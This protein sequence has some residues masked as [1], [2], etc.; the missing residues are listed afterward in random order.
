MRRKGTSGFP[1]PAA[2]P[3]GRLLD[4]APS[5]PSVMK[6]GV[7]LTMVWALYATLLLAVSGRE[8]AEP[9]LPALQPTSDL[10]TLLAAGHA[11][12][13]K[14]PK[15]HLLRNSFR[16]LNMMG[17][18]EGS[19]HGGEW[20][21]CRA[22]KEAELG[23]DKKQEQPGFDK[24]LH[25]VAPRPKAGWELEMSESQDAEWLG[26]HSFD[27]M[28][29]YGSEEADRRVEK[30]GYC[31]VHMPSIPRTGSTWFRAL[32][33]TATS[34]PSFSMWPEGGTLKERYTAFSS[35]DPCGASLDHM[36]GNLRSKA[37]FPCRDLRPPNATSP[38]LYKS[39]TPFFPSY[40]KPSLM[41][42]DTCM[43]VLLVRNP[44]DNHD[45]WQ[46]YMAG[47]APCLRDYLPV[48]QGHLSHWVAAAGDIPIYVFRY[49]D[50]LLRAEEVLRRILNTLPGGWNWSEESI[51]RAMSLF[52][53]KKP[54]KQ[55]CGAGVPRASLAEVEMVRRHYG[56]YMRH[57]GYR[58][59]ET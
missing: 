8:R 24:Y 3:A 32:F 55:K 11:A 52:G 23:P 57:F 17:F 41:P 34:Q 36:E 19:G 16:Q 47:K 49:E 43:L 42:E 26:L 15:P 54:F 53:P 25:P 5:A 21:T 58:F 7:A 31:R 39:H 35:D 45:A 51:A 38:I 22:Y 56:A 37:K 46:R 14:P 27:N 12:D 44:I 18:E 48:W 50:M 10:T 4:R 59:V 9:V 2:E 6:L 28:Y 13:P 20:I 30:A 1:D 40:N 33:E 29:E